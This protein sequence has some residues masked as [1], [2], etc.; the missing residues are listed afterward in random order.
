MDRLAKNAG[1][2]LSPNTLHKWING[3]AKPREDNIRKIALVLS[4]DEIWLDKGLRRD[5]ARKRQDNEA[6]GS[7]PIWHLAALLSGQGHTVSFPG[8]EEEAVHL[9]ANIGGDRIGFIAVEAST[10]DAQRSYVIP[11][12]VG[13][14]R[15]IAVSENTTSKNNTVC[16][17]FHDLTDAPRTWMGGFSVIQGEMKGNGQFEEMGSKGVFTPAPNPKELVTTA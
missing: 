6:R 4:V 17:T 3:T 5:S 10:T 9:Y 11:E 12:P 13:D 14:N 7:R 1:L 8:V 16:L 15:V 2:K